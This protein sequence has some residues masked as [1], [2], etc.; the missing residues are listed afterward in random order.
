MGPEEIDML[1]NLHRGTS[2]LILRGLNSLFNVP[3]IRTRF[4]V[5]ES[6]RFLHASLSDYLGDSR[7]SGP[8][9]VSLPWLQTEYVHCMI[10]LLSSPL[11]TEFTSGDRVRI[12][13]S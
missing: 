10:R 6:I 4:S 13:Y 8:W 11:P 2:R 12:F 3:P 9:C 7:R 5:R 1:L